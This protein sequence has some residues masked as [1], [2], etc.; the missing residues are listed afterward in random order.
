MSNAPAPVRAVIFLV[1]MISYAAAGYI[2]F[3]RIGGTR[4][5]GEVGW[6]EALWWAVVTMTTVGYGDFFPSNNMSRYIVAFPAML[7]GMGMLGFVLSQ[8]AGYLIRADALHRKG[9]LMK[10][11][12]G[13]VLVFNF[14]SKER[15]RAII[16]EIHS[17]VDLQN[18][19]I[20]L[21]DEDLEELDPEIAGD[22]VSFVRGNPALRSTLEAAGVKD[23][24]SAVILAKSSQHSSSDHL[25]V[26]ICMGAKQLS[27][28]LHVVAE[29]VEPA[30]QE[31]LERA[32]CGSIVCVMDLSPGLLA[33][34]LHDP[35][36]IGVLR[37]LTVWGDQLNNIFIIPIEGDVPG[38][39]VQALRAWSEG[40]LATLL[41]IRR[42]E[43]ISLNPAQST[44]LEKG[45]AAIIMTRERPSQVAL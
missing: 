13:H 25:S 28:E 29:C 14:P 7:A 39:D 40:K 22:H 4:A 27:K 6:A 31:L 9:L 33:H 16:D 1:A 37:E 44:K 2:Y 41:G 26:S 24:H 42:G 5:M 3:E 32:Q 23:A 17:Q 10:K 18:R 19:D 12:V 15:L 34:E 38:K 43:E 21:V 45:D 30:N 20:V 11:F 36:V 8:A 35:G